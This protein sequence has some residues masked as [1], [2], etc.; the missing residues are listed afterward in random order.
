LNNQPLRFTAWRLF[1]SRGLS[2]PLFELACVLARFD[3]APEKKLAHRL[4]R[5]F[6]D[7]GN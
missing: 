1:V 6:T 3:H 5:I 7:S 4:T 2:S